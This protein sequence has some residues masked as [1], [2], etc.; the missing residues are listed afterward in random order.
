MIYIK[1]VFLNNFEIKNRDQN[2]NY[3]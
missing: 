3:G 2:L 1:N